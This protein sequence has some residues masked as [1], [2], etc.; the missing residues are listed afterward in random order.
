M[1]ALRAQAHDQY[2]RSRLLA[3]YWSGM[4]RDNSP[5]TVAANDHVCYYTRYPDGGFVDA[6][7]LLCPR[8]GDGLIEILEEMPGVIPMMLGDLARCWGCKR[9]F[10][11]TENCW[12]WRKIKA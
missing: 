7:D 9:E 11:I 3:Q 5:T 8:C 1:Q 10:K 6:L 2:E 12:K 4:A